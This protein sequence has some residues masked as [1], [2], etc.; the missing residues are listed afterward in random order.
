MMPLGNVAPTDHIFP[1]THTYIYLPID[2]ARQPLAQTVYAPGD[3]TITRIAKSDHYVSSTDHTIRYTDYRL[4]FSFC[5]DLAGYF[6]LVYDLTPAVTDAVGSLTDGFDVGCNELASDSDPG[7]FCFKNI[8]QAKVIPAGTAIAKAGRS[9]VNQVFSLDFGV[10]DRRVTLTGYTE[11]PTFDTTLRDRSRRS[12]EAQPTGSA[13][14]RSDR[15]RG[16]DS[17]RWCDGESRS[18]GSRPAPV[19]GGADGR[20]RFTEAMPATSWWLDRGGRAIY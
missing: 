18:H 12:P 1:T 4:D 14:W 9:D 20:A 8:N 19:L 13:R 6:I 16:S 2:E 7:M 3:M 5:D 17:T 11:N 15:R 10:T